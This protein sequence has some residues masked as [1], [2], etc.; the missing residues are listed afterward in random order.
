RALLGA[1]GATLAAACAPGARVATPSSSAPVVVGPVETTTIT[2]DNQEGCET[3]TWLAEPFL[4]EEGFTEVRLADPYGPGV[5]TGKSDIQTNLGV[6]IAL[7]VNAG[8]PVV[9]LAGTHTGCIELWARPNI[10]SIGDLRGKRIVVNQKDVLADPTYSTWVSILATFG[11]AASEVSFTEGAGIPAF[12]DG[13]AD[14]VFAAIT[15]GPRLRADPNKTGHQIFDIGVDKPWSQY[16]CCLL[17]ANRDWAKRNPNAA[18]RATRAV[19]RAIDYGA[20]DHAR[21]VRAAVDKKVPAASVPEFLLE[22]LHHH[23]Y[24]WRDYDAEET[25]RFNALRLADAKLLTKTPSQV[26][27]EGSDFAFFRQLQKELPA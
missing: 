18:M 27:A 19:L 2:I 11:I 24:S 26:V 12:L 4:R 7:Q 15:G 3:W 22:A 21:T 25:I 6:A 9:A 13:Q 20:K 8:K 23:G 16:F 1:A 5:I 10:N 17:V 14:A